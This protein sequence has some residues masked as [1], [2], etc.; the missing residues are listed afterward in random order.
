MVSRCSASNA[1]YIP[2]TPIWSLFAY[3]NGQIFASRKLAARSLFARKLVRASLAITEQHILNDLPTLQ[4]L[5]GFP[6]ANI[7]PILGHGWLPHGCSI[8][9][10]DMELCSYDLGVYLRDC[11]IGVS[12]LLRA[13]DDTIFFDKFKLLMQIMKQIIN[14]L[15][16]LHAFHLVHRDLHPRNSE[17][18]LLCT[19]TVI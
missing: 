1:G 8:Y 9:F 18:F 16:F 11:K 13:G 15:A 2:K 19:L 14:G 17:F 6:H 10:I 12:E 5:S 4:I 3:P 7:V